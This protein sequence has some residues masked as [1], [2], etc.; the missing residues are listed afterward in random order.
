MNKALKIAG[1]AVLAIVVLLLALF[2]YYYFSRTIPINSA[3][4]QMGP[5]ADTLTAG[6][7]NFRDLNKNGS[8]DPY[9][10]RRLAI[11]ARVEDLLARMTV[12]EKAGMMFHSFLTIGPDGDLA[13]ALNPLNVLP[14]QV[15]LFGKKMNFFN[16]FNVPDVTGLARWHNTVQRL[17]ER[18]RLG[19][20][21]TISSD[22]RHT[23]MKSGAA[24]GFYTEG[25]SHWTEPIGF[26]AIGDPELVRRFGQIA[27]REYRAVGIHVAL[28][29]MVDLAT[30]PRWGRISGTFGEDAEVAAE[31]GA[32]YINGFQGDSL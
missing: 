27:A 26:G 5:P 13:G 4:G 23:A 9:E 24:I 29:P 12:E 28:H 16:L 19:I 32:A 2:G 1:Y 20:P 31:L 21:V 22:P 18:T 3:T 10:D 8:L 25:F 14:V 7:M 30:E 15:A 17:A 11:E 6:G